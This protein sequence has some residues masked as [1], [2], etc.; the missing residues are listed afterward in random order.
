MIS[1]IDTHCHL[2][3]KPYAADFGGV[4]QRAAAVGV[5][6]II[7]IGIDLKSSQ[8]AVALSDEY[9][10]IYATV[11][12]HPHGANEIG[13][14]DF[15]ALRSLAKHPKVVGY[16]EVGLDFVKKYAPEQVQ[17]EQFT[18]QVLMA[19]ELSLPLVIHDRDAHRQV[20][21]IL[22][23]HGP[24]AAGGVM[25]CFSGDLRLAKETLDLGFYVSIPGI[26]TF[27]NAAILQEVAVKLPL[28]SLLLETDGPYLAPVP[29]RG[30]RN[31]PSYLVYTAEKIAQL[32][33]IGLD[34]V[35]MVTTAN[36]CKLFR[37]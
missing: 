10:N 31:E 7:S 32:R 15:E 18:E 36:A 20:M 3:M 35:A 5:E 16:G 25:H 30:R 9:P 24:Y 28:S 37:L 29:K 26:V 2:D 13:E 33:G 12:I 19:K 8:R 6:R 1:L 27:S 4:L 34:E 14:K 11:G 23:S 21:S 17:L 22:Q